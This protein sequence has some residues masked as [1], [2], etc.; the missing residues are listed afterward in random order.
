MGSIFK[1]TDSKS[2]LKRHGSQFL[3]ISWISMM[4]IWVFA[5]N[6]MTISVLKKISTCCELLCHKLKQFQLCSWYWRRIQRPTVAWIDAG[7]FPFRSP[8]FREHV[9]IIVY[10]FMPSNNWFSSQSLLKRIVSRNVSLNPVS[11]M[12]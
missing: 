5:R 1:I 7:L 2:S 9:L 12:H 6:Q 11:Q 10:Y 4:L 8:L 3:N